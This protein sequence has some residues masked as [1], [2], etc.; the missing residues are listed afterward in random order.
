M[1]NKKFLGKNF[2]LST[3]TA[4]ALYHNYA[5]QLPIIDY[6]CHV[7]PKEIAMDKKYNNITEIWLGGDHY[8]WRAIRSCGVPE[9]YITGGASDYD[10][11]K[12]YAKIMPKLIGNPLYHWSHLE[13]KRYFGYGGV[14]NED[15][16]D[17]VWEVCNA[18]LAEPS[19]SVKNIIKNSKV[20]TLCTTDDPADTLEYHQEIADSAYS[21]NVLPA[22]RPDKGINCDRKGYVE[23]IEKLSV[24]SGVCITDID[25]L[26]QAYVNRIDFFADNG[27]VTADH[28]IDERI[29]FALPEHKGQADEVFKRALNGETAITPLETD[30]FKTEMLNFF[31]GEYKKRAWVMQIHFG[32]LRNVN[33][34]MLAKLGPDTGYDVIGGKTSIT[35][36]A[37]VLDLIESSGNLPRTIIYSANPTDNAGI[38]ALI[39]AFQKSDEET[40]IPLL[41]HG[42]AWWFNDNYDGMRKQMIDLANLSALGNFVGMLTD[43]RSFISYTRHEYFRRILCDM[44]GNWVES[45]QFPLDTETLAKLVMDI[46]YN[47]TKNFFAF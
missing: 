10:K 17:E 6:H 20:E 15:T 41:Q 18:K 7:S 36:L 23:Y 21:V 28:G 45:G 13:L 1:S 16:C 26:K 40:G 27:C 42:S 44:I 2:L 32:V 19:M 5:A 35:E 39:G 38:G 22:F 4:K 8:K 34:V 43:S 33:S 3:N 25:S 9:D 46:S 29:P 31:A 37:R 30:I 12:V 47:N 11:F 24:A 14:F